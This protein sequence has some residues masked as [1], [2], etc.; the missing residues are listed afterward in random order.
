MKT[1]KNLYEKVISFENLLYATEKAFKGTKSKDAYKFYFNKENEIIKLIREL[2]EENFT[3][4]PYRY[5]TITDPKEREIS[6]ATFRDRVVHHSIVNILEPIYEKS[7]IAHSYA[8]RKEKGTH[9]AILQ[10][11][12]YFKTNEWYLKTDVKKHFESIDH[13]IMINILKRKIGDRKL[14]N[15]IEKII[16][17]ASDSG[18]SLPIGNLTSQF[19]ANVYLDML[20]HYIK[21]KIGIKA[22]V[23]YMDDIVVLSN[24]KEEL[25]E[26]RDKIREFLENEL[27]LNLKEKATYINSQQNGISFCGVRIFPNIIRIKNENL[28]RYMK[29]I[30]NKI[31]D[32]E[33]N[34]IA[35][36]ELELSL[37][38]Y[39]AMFERYNTYRLRN[40]IWVI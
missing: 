14:I 32:F 20:D 31:K 23:R 7:F 12:K 30:K 15:L 35:E 5:F 37:N 16:R 22:Y 29:K 17:N 19:F 39:N 21:D 8:T 2:K 4:S 13:E 33:N 38:S 9:K 24:N 40:Q 27:K 25:K 3:P 34:K 28:K 1:Y 36:E 6:I 11:Q 18:K 10:V 26:I